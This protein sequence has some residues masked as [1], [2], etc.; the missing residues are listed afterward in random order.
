VYYIKTNAN[1]TIKASRIL[2]TL[3][4][5]VGTKVVR[6]D[7]EVLIQAFRSDYPVLLVKGNVELAIKSTSRTLSEDDVNVNFNRA[8]VPYGGVT[9]ADEW[10]T[11]PVKIE[12]LVHVQGAATFKESTEIRGALLVTGAVTSDAY[13]QI[14][15]DPALLTNPPV[16]YR[17]YFYPPVPGGWQRVVD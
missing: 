11:Y 4:V 10:D 8:G 14:T 7:D 2:G 3:L 16:G 9:D 15:H 13:P 6:L 12:G 17:A 1:L 5:D